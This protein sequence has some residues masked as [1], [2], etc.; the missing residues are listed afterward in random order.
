MLILLYGLE[1]WCV[2]KADEHRRLSSEMNWLRG[3]LRDLRL[4]KIKY[5]VTRKPIGQ[6]IKM[7]QKIKERCVKNGPERILCME[8]HSRVQG[9]A[10]RGRLRMHWIDMVKNYG[11][12]K[13]LK[14]NE[15][16][17]LVQDVK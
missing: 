14:I 13:G 7:L 6:E 8:V 2:R 16:I 10:N 5:D 11:E 1:R 12:Q 9:T 4:Q 3:V 15:S 17:K